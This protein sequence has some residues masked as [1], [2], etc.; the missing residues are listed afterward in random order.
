MSIVLFVSTFLWG[1]HDLCYFQINR[2]LSLH[3]APLYIWHAI[4]F[5]LIR[6]SLRD[7]NHFPLPSHSANWP[8]SS[9]SKTLFSRYLTRRIRQKVRQNQYSIRLMVVGS[10]DSFDWQHLFYWNFFP[11]FAQ[12]AQFWQ[13]KLVAWPVLSFHCDSE[14]NQY[15]VYKV[16]M[17]WS[18]W[19]SS[20][21]CRRSAL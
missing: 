13:Y 1:N 14:F 6:Q 5:V 3:L 11:K 18:L 17:H 16:Q 19:G 20:K 7:I 9:F 12:L 15:I 4:M 2:H 21:A 10:W 8:N